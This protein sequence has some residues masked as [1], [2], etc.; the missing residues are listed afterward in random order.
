MAVRSLSPEE[1]FTGLLWAPSSGSM[2][3]WS[4]WTGVR[5]GKVVDAETSLQKQMCGG[6]VF[7]AVGW[8]LLSH[9]GRGLSFLLFYRDIFSYSILGLAQWVKDQTLP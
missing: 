4:D 1:G 5:S 3:G 7:G 2:L 8:T 6:G 9:H